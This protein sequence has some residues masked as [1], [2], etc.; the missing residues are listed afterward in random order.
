[1]HNLNGLTR[2]ERL[3]EELRNLPDGLDEAYVLAIEIEFRRRGA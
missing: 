1:M 2:V 3:R